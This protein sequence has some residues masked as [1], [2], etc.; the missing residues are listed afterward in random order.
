MVTVGMAPRLPRT[1]CTEP[2]AL[3]L[4]PLA[5]SPS[6]SGELVNAASHPTLLE[7]I[8]QRVRPDLVSMKTYPFWSGLSGMAPAGAGG[9][10]GVIGG[11]GA[12]V[13]A[14]VAVC[15]GVGKDGSVGP[16]PGV[17]TGLPSITVPQP[18]TSALPVSSSDP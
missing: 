7:L 9:V 12:A 16:V 1:H 4:T 8:W 17:A 13:G 11:R 10:V 18:A 3:M 5:C 6:C 15:L 14:A 2:L